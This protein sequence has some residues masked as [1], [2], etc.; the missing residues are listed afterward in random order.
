MVARYLGWRPAGALEW[1]EL[2]EFLLARAME[3]DSPTLLFRLACEHLISAQVIR[4]GPVTL[5]E[6]VATA[7]AAAERETYQR[8][9]HL[10]SGNRPGELDQLLVVDPDIGGTR[11]G[12]LSRGPTEPS[13]AV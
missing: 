6:R 2:A 7:R 1:K 13:P 10:L 11:L 8:V 9:A 4:P 3:H 5:V 12:W